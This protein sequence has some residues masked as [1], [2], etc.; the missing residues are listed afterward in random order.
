MYLLPLPLS[1]LILPYSLYPPLNRLPSPPPPPHLVSPSYTSYPLISSLL[2][3][4]LSFPPVFLTFFLLSLHYSSFLFCP[5]FLPPT[6]PPL[7]FPLSYHTTPK[8]RPSKDR[9]AYYKRQQRENIL[10]SL[11]EGASLSAAVLSSKQ[12]THLYL[13][14]YLFMN[15]FPYLYLHLS[16]STY[17]TS[18][19]T[20]SSSCLSSS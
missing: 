17:S 2:Y 8:H 18:S 6:D 5:L 15:L 20:S 16:V 10:N 4:L 11:I 12:V 19:S 9:E 14:F 13:F 7:L 1:Y 3:I